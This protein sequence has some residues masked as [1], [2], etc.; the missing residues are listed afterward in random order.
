MYFFLQWGHDFRPDYLSLSNIRREFPQVPI[1]ALT[2]T[3]NEKVV[4][5]SLRIIGMFYILV[6][7]TNAMIELL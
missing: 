7:C 1:M 5:D 2:A 4:A 3:A 6:K